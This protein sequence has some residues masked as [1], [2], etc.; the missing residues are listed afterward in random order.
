MAKAPADSEPSRKPVGW[1]AERLFRHLTKTTEPWTAEQL[2][3]LFHMEGKKAGQAA[4]FK[5]LARLLREKVLTDANVAALRDHL[6]GLIALTM[7]LTKMGER[8]AELQARNAELA[9]PARALSHMRRGTTSTK[10]P[11]RK[12]VLANEELMRRVLDP[13]VKRAGLA[14]RIEAWLAKKKVKHP[15][16]QAIEHWIKKLRKPAAAQAR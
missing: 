4:L 16:A 2:A 1:T 15:Q 3:S 12:R 14:R 9:N 13:D 11:W 5:V 10:K 7:P 6:G 8:A